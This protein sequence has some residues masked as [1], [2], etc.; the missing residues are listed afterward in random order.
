MHA[1]LAAAHS[2]W[3]LCQPWPQE[4]TDNYMTQDNHADIVLMTALP[5]ERDALLKYLGPAQESKAKGRQYH[6]GRVGPYEV[7]VWSA[8]GMGN[9]QAG[10]IATEAIGI[11]NPSHI[12]LAGYAGGVKKKNERYLGDVLVP[13]QVM[14]YELGKEKPEG[15]ERRYEAYRPSRVL[16]DAAKTLDPKVWAMSIETPRPD[17]TSGREV[18]R[19]HVGTVGSGE[20]VITAP[21]VIKDLQGDWVELIGVDMESLGVAMAAYQSDRAPG[22]LVVKGI[23]DWADPT[24]S[25]GWQQYAAE[26]AACFTVALLH[27]QPLRVSHREQAVPTNRPTSFSGRAKLAVCRRL[28]D[29]WQDLADIC[30]IPKHDRARFERGREPAGV[31]EWLDAHGK[32]AFLPPFLEAIGR[33]DLIGELTDRPS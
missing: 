25:D 6:R 16:L 23:S 33:T 4:S 11:W 21:N 19:T 26:A 15:L 31:W 3:E 8:L 14:G 28:V 17:G 5:L 13:D 9:V 1:E 18:P 2:H 27:A 22:F 32:L 24:K 10:V 20:K 7:V 29:D 12:I 30:D